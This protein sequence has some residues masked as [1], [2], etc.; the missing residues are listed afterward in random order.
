MKH[1]K[2]TILDLKLKVRILSTVVFFGAVGGVLYATKAPIVSPCPIDGCFVKIVHADEEKVDILVDT[3]ASKYGKT[4]YE[5][6]RIKALL[7]YLL[8]REQNYGSSEACGDG[9]KACGP[10]QFHEPTYISYRSMMIKKGL[11]K[12][13]GSRLNMKDAI[14][15]T[16]WAIANGKEKAWGPVFRGEIKI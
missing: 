9:G 7:H 6:N 5:R 16:A 3:Y 10:L 14:E 8:L 4:S 12:E 2:Q 11:V 15:T 1:N 13:M